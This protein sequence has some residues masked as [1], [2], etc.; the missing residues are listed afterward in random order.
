M[1]LHYLPGACSL[2]DHIVLEWI[3]KPY[4]A[5]A[6][7]RDRLKSPEYLRINPAGS[8][9]ALETDEG[10][11]LT[12]NSAILHYLAERNPEAG[13][14]GDGSARS[15]AEVDRWL[16]FVNAD[17]HPS[18]WPFFG[19]LSW[20]D[21]DA[22]LARGHEAARRKLRGLFE[23]ADR[24]LEGRD[25]IAGARSIADPYLYVV[26]RWAKAKQVD[27]A[28]LANL[29]R[30]FQRMQADPAVQRVLEAEGL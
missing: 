26:T 13:L 11:P 30:H 15:R 17:V 3:G 21:D 14:H 5:V 18:F 29:E 2:A 23:R 16:A 24:Q 7:P 4:E 9:P 1:K 12:Q 27:L 25:W 6:V 20:L 19:G 10:W 28:G 22:M 8:V